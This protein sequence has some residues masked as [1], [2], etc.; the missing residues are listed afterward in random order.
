MQVSSNDMDWQSSPVETPDSVAG[1]GDHDDVLE[2]PDREAEQPAIDAFSQGA[3]F[4]ERHERVIDAPPEAVYRALQDLRADEIPLF[5]LLMGARG[6]LASG[7]ERHPDLPILEEAQRVGFTRL[8]EKPGREVVLGTIGK[9]WQLTG[10]DTVR[11]ADPDE[12][13]SFDRPGYAKAVLGFSL[14]PLPGGRTRLVTE[15]RVSPTD[16]ETASKFKRYWFFVK[17]GSGLIRRLWL[18]SVEKRAE[19]NS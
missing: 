1:A 14:E 8:A 9:F 6:A 16:A 15:T 5:G 2:L 7:P 17:S 3:R 19:A 4:S 10:P 18:R 12:F 11:V 13:Q